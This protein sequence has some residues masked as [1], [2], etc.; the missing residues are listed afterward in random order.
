MEEGIETGQAPKPVLHAGDQTVSAHYG[1]GYRA[2]CP[3]LLEDST[4]PTL[5]AFDGGTLP[6]LDGGPDVD[7]EVVTGTPLTVSV[8][9]WSEDVTLDYFHWSELSG[10][11]RD[12]TSTE[13]GSGLWRLDVAPDPGDYV[14]S[15]QFHWE[16][17]ED[18][19]A[20]HI[21]VVE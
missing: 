1:Y 20:W 7:V 21:R 3:W 4:E 10:G 18:S 15:V 13:V 19:W 9:P 12:L 5:M 16:Y 14:L 8:D 17:G 2:S 11:G 6:G